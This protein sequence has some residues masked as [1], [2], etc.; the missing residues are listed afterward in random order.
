MN[1]TDAPSNPTARA[2]P[3]ELDRELARIDE[4][5][6]KR[7]QQHQA[8]EERRAVCAPY[9]KE[10]PNLTVGEALALDRKARPEAYRKT[11]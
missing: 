10:N 3:T 1:A 7:R 2:L 4:R 6:D 9:M 5:L 8:L 11:N